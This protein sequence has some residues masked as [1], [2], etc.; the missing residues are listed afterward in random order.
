MQ[1]V[2]VVGTRQCRERVPRLSALQLGGGELYLECRHKRMQSV[3]TISE[4]KWTLIAA[5]LG[6]VT[7]CF[8]WIDLFLPGC[9][10]QWPDWPISRLYVA[11]LLLA[12]ALGFMCK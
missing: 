12:T 7:Y 1:R 2:V 8:E 9:C 10:R 11:P 5:S 6:V 3:Q 4:W